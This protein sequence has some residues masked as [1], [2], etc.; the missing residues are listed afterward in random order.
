LIHLLVLAVAA[1][2]LQDPAGDAVGDGT[3]VPPTAP[4][5]AN[6]ADFDLQSVTLTSDPTLTVRVQ[7]GSVSDA[8]KLPN[9]FSNPIIEIYLDTAPGGAQQLL[10]GSGMAMPP[11]H[12]WEIAL[13]ATGDEAYAVEAQS[14]GSPASWPRLPVTVDV[15]GNAI[16]LHTAIPRPGRADLYALTGVYDPFTKDGW[17][18]LTASVSPW[19]FSSP[20]QQVPVVD[21]LASSQHAQRREID[22]G[23]LSPYRSP[24]H[25]VGWLVLMVLGL[26]T[27]AAGLVLRRRV[28]APVRSAA[29]LGDA[30]PPE[31]ASSEPAIQ[32]AGSDDEGHVDGHVVERSDGYSDGYTD[33]RGHGNSDGRS[34]AA[35]APSMIHERFLDEEEE[36]A[37]WPDA[38]SSVDRAVADATE[39]APGAT[40][41]APWAGAAQDGTVGAAEGAVG[42]DAG[43]DAGGAVGSN[44]G[45]AVGSDAGGNAGSPDRVDEGNAEIG[46]GAVNDAG[47][48]A[49]TERG[50]DTAA[51]P[52]EAPESA[53]F[54][55]GPSEDRAG[56]DEA[57]GNQ[58][59]GNEAV[60][61]QAVADQASEDEPSED[62]AVKDAAVADRAVADRA[63]ADRAV[64]DQVVAETDVTDQVVA[65]T[66]VTDTDF[67]DTDPQDT[68][69]ADADETASK[70]RP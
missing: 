34:E 3:L 55:D 21:L 54:D 47:T 11:K 56:D 19:A 48:E 44:V 67:A 18:P 27:A 24:L 58:A 22:S 32:G 7:L 38:E 40:Q 39:G 13:R 9:G 25:G 16:T 20:S 53:P 14:Q 15:Q 10:P 68:G 57:V 50:T 33:G 28:R 12:G 5:Y 70:R 51:R 2:H 36:A 8:A 4:V 29:A 26:V 66:D 46:T 31:A 52:W 59:S 41:G 35:R 45:R 30:T 6:T 61:D 23:V 65:D 62:H 42:G 17:R 60:E 64:A 1:L 49:S 63:V 43:G 37:L 69:G